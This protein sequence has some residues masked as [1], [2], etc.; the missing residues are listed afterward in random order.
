MVTVYLG[1]K[2]SPAKLGFHGENHWIY[3]GYD[4]DQAFAERQQLLE[5]H[6]RMCYLS[7]QSLK[8][9]HA[10]TH[11]AQVISFLDYDR[12]E[13]FKEE[14]WRHRGEAYEALKERI[15]ESL[16]AFIEQRYPG[17]RDLVSYV[18]VSTPLTV[19]NFTGHVRGSVYGVPATPERFRLPYLRVQT[20]VRGLYLT[21]AD[22]GSLGIMGGLMGGVATSSR[23]L[24]PLGFLRIMGTARRLAAA[25]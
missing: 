18:E 20:P 1:L 25:G 3:T 14:P 9:P 11:A 21:G 17:F 13:A 8:D 4:H 16:L 23:L 2:E 7:L 6:P 22:V 15:A 10:G 12:V 24:G 19:E 5:G